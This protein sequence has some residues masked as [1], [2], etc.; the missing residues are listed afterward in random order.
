MKKI[1]IFQMIRIIQDAERMAPFCISCL[2]RVTSRTS[3]KSRLSKV[4]GKT[5]Q[6]EGD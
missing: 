1:W 4:E 6:Q 2:Q 3:A 5:A